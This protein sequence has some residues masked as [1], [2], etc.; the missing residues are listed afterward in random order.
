LLAV[1][2]GVVFYSLLAIFPAVAAFVSL[3][4]LIAEA[5][6]IDAHLSLAAGILPSGAVDIL[7][8]QI[9]RLTAKSHNL[10]L[11]FI[12]GLAVALWS[13]NTGMENSASWLMV[14]TRPIWP[15]GDLAV[16]HVAVEGNPVCRPMATSFRSGKL[17]AVTGRR[18]SVCMG[19]PGTMAQDLILDALRPAR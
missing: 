11:G 5:S 4:G 13:A 9:T 17:R 1:A 3:Y 8:E 2:A 15:S 16:G 10:G 6:T 14:P 19:A 7:H 18:F 12:T